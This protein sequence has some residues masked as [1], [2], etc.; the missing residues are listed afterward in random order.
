MGGRRALRI[1]I[2]DSGVNPTHPAVGA[3]AGGCDLRWDEGRVVRGDDYRDLLGHGTA[4]AAT[5]RSH[6]P[7][8]DL[9]A[10]RI[11]RRRLVA[12]AET[13]AAAI[14]WA[15]GERLDVVNLSLGMANRGR[16]ALLEGVVARA[17]EAGVVL[18]AAAHANGGPS[19]PGALGGVV[20]VLADSR[21]PRGRYRIEAGNERKEALFYASPWAHEIPGLPRERNF[22]GLSLAVANLSGIIG[23]AIERH[24]PDG[25]PALLGI[26]A[27]RASD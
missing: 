5:I 21:L 22:H 13:L 1:G 15:T 17:V 12:H 9:V 18:V 23:R 6:L 4:V 3:V 16:R 26:L 20:G 11:F 2:I 25:L 14:D 19:L 8:A 27:A 10:I 7:D 24:R